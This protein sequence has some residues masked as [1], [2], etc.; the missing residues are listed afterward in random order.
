MLVQLVHL[1]FGLFLCSF[2]Q[3]MCIFLI[4]SFAL[5]FGGVQFCSFAICFFATFQILSNDNLQVTQEWSLCIGLSVR[6]GKCTVE[7]DAYKNLKGIGQ[8]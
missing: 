6:P 2:V 1:H 4:I 5:F 7:N 8:P 3:Y